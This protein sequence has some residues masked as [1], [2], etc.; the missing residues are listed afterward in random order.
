VTHTEFVA[1]W[2]QG[3]VAVAVDAAAAGAF[4]SA[5]LLLPFFAIAVIGLGIALI[6][7][8]WLWTGVGIG[9]LGIV[10]PR[11]IKRG[12]RHFLLTQ[13]ATDSELF[14]AAVSSGAL[15]VVP[16]QVGDEAAAAAGD[17]R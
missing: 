10:G 3:R 14:A 1:A 15:R 11:A 13:I 16:N 12:A 4:I 9:V 5:R 8:G 17:K 6:L 7:S 2:Q